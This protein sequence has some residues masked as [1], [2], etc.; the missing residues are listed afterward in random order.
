VSSII[1]QGRFGSSTMGVATL[2]AIYKLI[3]NYDGSKK[4]N[5]K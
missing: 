4:Y 1:M 2:H 5:G 3:K